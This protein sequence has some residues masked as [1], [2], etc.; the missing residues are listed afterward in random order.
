M[1]DLARDYAAY[2]AAKAH[3]LLMTAEKAEVQ[4]VKA[5]KN[6]IEQVR[7][8]VSGAFTQFNA[9][10]DFTLKLVTAHALTALALAG[11]T[12][13]LPDHQRPADHEEGNGQ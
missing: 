3:E 11:V 1:A 6:P 8:A 5:S 10:Q 2:H 9:N 13:P 7:L 12:G 4:M